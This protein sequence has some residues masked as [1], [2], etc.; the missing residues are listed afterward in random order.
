MVAVGNAGR[1]RQRVE[2]DRLRLWPKRDTREMAMAHQYR[3][4][5]IALAASLF[6]TTASA[7]SLEGPYRGT[8]VCEKLK[9]AAFML[10]APLDLIIR[11][12]EAIFARPIFGADGVRVAGTELATGTLGSD[13]KLHATAV[14]EDGGSGFTGDYG[15]TLSPAGGTLTGTETWHLPNGMTETRSCT[16]ALVPVHDVKQAAAPK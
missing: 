8:L 11:G 12:N 10:R 7:Q 14:W 4:I 6:A 1:C 3:N 13:G 15:G 2:N 5:L 16:A 9:M